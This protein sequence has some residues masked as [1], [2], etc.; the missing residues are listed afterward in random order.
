[1]NRPK[2]IGLEV[3]T[4]MEAGVRKYKP[5]AILRPSGKAPYSELLFK[6]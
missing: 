2:Q 6:H 3:A 1:M 4:W 5:T